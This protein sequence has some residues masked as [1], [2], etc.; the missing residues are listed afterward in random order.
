MKATIL[1][2]SVAL[3][4]CSTEPQP[5][6]AMAGKARAAPMVHNEAVIIAPKVSPTPFAPTA[7]TDPAFNEQQL[8]A[9]P[10][11]RGLPGDVQH[12]IARYEDCQHWAGEEPYDAERGNEISAAIEETCRGIDAKLRKLTTRYRSSPDV[13]ATLARYKTVGS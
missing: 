6:N 8:V 12:F 10:K 5:G 7:E 3:C 4:A 13:A 1:F 11:A 9:Y 2:A